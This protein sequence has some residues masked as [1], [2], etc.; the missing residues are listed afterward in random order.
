MALGGLPGR[1]LRLVVQRRLRAGNRG[2]L[3]LGVPVAPGCVIA[4]SS[5]H[6]MRS[7]TSLLPWLPTRQS[8]CFLRMLGLRF[9]PR[10]VTMD[11]VVVL[12]AFLIVLALVG[13]V[14]ASPLL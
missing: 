8:G 3:L 5:R 2:I 14:A 7:Y 1:V 12:L 9:G 11:L 6:P 4:A 10:V 13:N